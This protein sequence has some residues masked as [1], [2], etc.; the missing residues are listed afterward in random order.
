MFLDSIF[1]FFSARSFWAFIWILLAI[2]YAFQI[3]RKNIGILIALS[4]A[5]VLTVITVNLG[6]KNIV[7]RLRPIDTLPGVVEIGTHT[8]SGSFPSTHAAFSFAA[9]FILARVHKKYKFYFYLIAF[10]VSFS[11][12]YLGKHFP[13]DVLAGALI[14]I[15]IGYFSL[16]VSTILASYTKHLLR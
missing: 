8:A 13:S 6:L 3:G 16:K 15:L 7:G 2:G 5:G 14:G 1:S 10:I 4:L 12:I 9:A 11:R